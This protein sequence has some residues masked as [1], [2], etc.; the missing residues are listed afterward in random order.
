MCHRASSQSSWIY[1]GCNVQVEVGS[2]LSI[3]QSLKDHR[4]RPDP[5]DKDEDCRM[6]VL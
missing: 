4:D 6:H 2:G 5:S 3:W 1:M